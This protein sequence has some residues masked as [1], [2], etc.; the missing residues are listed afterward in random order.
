MREAVRIHGFSTPVAIAMGKALTVA[1]FMSAGFK[2]VGNKLTLIIDGDGEGGK[3]V[4]CG[5]FGAKVRGYIQ[6]S[7]GLRRKRR[8]ACPM[9]W[10]KRIGSTS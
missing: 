2:G 4:L 9:S 10:V 6:K 3:M 8:R 7:Q 1:A 5:D